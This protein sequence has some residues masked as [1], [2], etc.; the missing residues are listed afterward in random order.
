MYTLA[1]NSKHCAITVLLVSSHVDYESRD[2]VSLH[3]VFPH[4]AFN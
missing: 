1:K 2:L 4:E 3:F